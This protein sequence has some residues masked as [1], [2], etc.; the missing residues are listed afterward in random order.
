[1]AGLTAT[2][3]LLLA[4]SVLKAGD[5]ISAVGSSSEGDRFRTIESRFKGSIIDSIEI[6]NRNIY[7]LQDRRYKGF[8]FRAADHLHIVTK[9]QI[10]RQELLFSVGDKFDPELVAETAR[11]LRT[12]F[13]FNDAWIET[14]QIGPGRVLVRVVTIDQWSLV[15]GL[16]SINREGQETDMRIG[17]DERNLLGRAQF[18]SFDVYLREK[19]PDYMQVAYN[20][21]RLLGKRWAV[22]LTYRSDPHNTLKQFELS[23][24]Y[25]S[26]AQRLDLYLHVQNVVVLN[27]FVGSDGAV[28]AEWMSHGDQ[29]AMHAGLRYGPP[30]RKMAVF[31]DYRYVSLRIRDTARYA[32]GYADN[33]FPADST[34]H[35]FSLGSSYQ[36]LN[37]IVEKR[38]RGFG[39]AE[40]VTLGA[41]VGLAYGRAFLPDFKSYYYDLLRAELAWSGKRGSNLLNVVY[42]RS[43]WYKYS[44]ELRRHSVLDLIWYN[45]RLTFLTLAMKSHFESDRGG[46]FQRLVLGGKSGLRGYPTEF[47]SGDRLHV[48]NFEGRFFTGLE[49]LSVKLGAALLA[50]VGRA[51]KLSEP[52]NIR[53]YHWSL[54][55]G[56][57]FSLENLLRGEII[58]ADLARTEDGFWELSMGAG[59]YF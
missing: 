6:D 41:T 59:L 39:Y 25:Y 17:F 15:G 50:D 8:L 54:G 10:V 2:I 53:G 44:R 46:V 4:P 57:R 16:R 20:E 28:Q 49:L 14:K 33:A 38:L 43:Y 7:D 40:D 36:R 11:N 1:M 42:S 12:R 3:W 21:P 31:G 48:I 24:P 22:G 9:Q 45:N 47:S 23:R 18:F 34:Y 5:V 58:R 35:F 56:L 52:L 32:A 27:R 19:H 30:R 51:W 55:A 37:F 26:L 29:V 13:P